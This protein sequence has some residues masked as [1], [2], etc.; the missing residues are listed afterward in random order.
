M[1]AAVIRPTSSRRT[2]RWLALEVQASEL[3]RQ[4]RTAR[5][6]LARWIG[7][8]ADAPL[9]G[10]PAIDSIRLD[11]GALDTQLAHHPQISVLAKQEEIA[12]TEVRIAQADKKAD[13]SME[14][15]YSQR[16]PAYSNMVS[17]GVSIPLQWDQRDRQDRE[18]AAKLALVDQAKAEREEALRAHTGEVRAM[19]AEWE[20]GRERLRAL[21]T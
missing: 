13:W 15:I 3:D 10:R 19:I 4:I 20:N 17:I 21:R 16:G 18:L 9:S 1:P 12:S 2:A 14:L 6:N 11:P 7:E 5:I 8:G